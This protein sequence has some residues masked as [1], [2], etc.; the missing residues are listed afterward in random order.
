MPSIARR[1]TIGQTLVRVR[2]RA[3]TEHNLKRE[4]ARMALSESVAV[5]MAEVRH[6]LFHAMPEFVHLGRN[7]E[8]SELARK[9]T[10]LSLAMAEL[11]NDLVH[12]R[13]VLIAW[14]MRPKARRAKRINANGRPGATGPTAQPLARAEHNLDHVSAI[15][16]TAVMEM[17]PNLKPVTK[18]AV[19]V[20]PT[21]LL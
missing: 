17:Q 7:G 1:G 10:R 3:E 14:A 9:T 11:R 18:I 8:L 4:L 5:T 2:S 12:A 6:K 13:M 16:M 19:H 20:R 21:A 15:L